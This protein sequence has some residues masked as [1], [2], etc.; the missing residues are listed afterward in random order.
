M[1]IWW[2]PTWQYLRKSFQAKESYGRNV[3]NYWTSRLKSLRQQSYSL[4]WEKSDRGQHGRDLFLSL[5]VSLKEHSHHQ[6]LS[7]W[8]VVVQVAFAQTA[9][10][11]VWARLFC[12]HGCSHSPLYS[13]HTTHW[14]NGITSSHNL[15]NY[16][17]MI[18]LCKGWFSKTLVYKT[19]K[20]YG[21]VNQEWEW[22]FTITYG[23]YYIPN[24]LWHLKPALFHHSDAWGIWF[25][26]IP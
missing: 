25:K 10:S 5:Q 8:P 18:N 6:N 20:G 19:Y 22:A 7:C 17:I 12:S 26:A 1:F 4:L 15:A 9:D 2:R 13:H 3:I 24:S 23:A 11:E 21:K 14:H 16:C